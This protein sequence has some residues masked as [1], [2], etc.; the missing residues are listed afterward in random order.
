M[1]F[2]SCF[3]KANWI[4]A[5][6]GTGF[7]AVRDC[8]F[9]EKGESAIINILGFGRFILFLNGQRVHDELFLPLC[10][11]FENVDRKG[12]PADE[13]MAARCYVSRFD[14]SK[15]VCD[16]NNISLSNFDFLFIT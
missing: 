3:G 16:G 7:I 6:S 11:N 10:S 14:I 12:I 2:E 9:A 13:K 4:G 5:S 1:N 15:F 8:F